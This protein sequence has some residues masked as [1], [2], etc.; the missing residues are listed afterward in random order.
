[1]PLEIYNE[2]KITEQVDEI[3]Q[4]GHP[5]CMMSYTLSILLKGPGGS[6]HRKMTERKYLLYETSLLFKTVDIYIDSAAIFQT[7]MVAATAVLNL[8]KQHLTSKKKLSNKN[9]KPLISEIAGA[10]SIRNAHFWIL[11]AWKTSCLD[12]AH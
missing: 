8:H 6:I 1:M 10:Q 4:N 3:N 11:H 7:W 2:N 12:E 5:T 9:I